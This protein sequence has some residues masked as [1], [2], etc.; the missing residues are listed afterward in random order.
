[1]RLTCNYA[2]LGRAVLRPRPHRALSRVTSSTRRIREAQ[3]DPDDYISA[4]RRHAVQRHQS[5]PL[6]EAAAAASGQ[7]QA[8]RGSP[9]IVRRTRTPPWDVFRAAHAPRADL[10]AAE[11]RGA[12]RPDFD[13]LLVDWR[14]KG[15]TVAYEGK[16]ALTGTE[17][18]KLK[19]TTKAGAVRYIYLDTTTYLDRRHRASWNLQRTGTRISS[20]TSVAG[21]EW[22]ASCSRLT[23]AGYSGAA[24]WCG[25]TD[26]HRQD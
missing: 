26:L 18:H 4:D 16:Q 23:S 17:T 13:G 22:T 7:K 20:W 25:P 9:P 5:R 6:Q 2:R 14:A 24:G 21:A 10:A 19:V 1:M 12:R 3:V 11:T 8:P 15:H